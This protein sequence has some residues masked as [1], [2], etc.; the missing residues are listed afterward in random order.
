LNQIETNPP[1]QI[2]DEIKS[3]VAVARKVRAGDT[4]EIQSPAFQQT[5]GKIDAYYFDN[6]SGQ[7]VPAK[8]ID[9]AYDGL[10]PTYSAGQTRFKMENTGKEVHEMVIA[11]LKP[12]VNKT[13][14]QILKLPESQ[15]DK[16]VVNVTQAD[17]VPAGQS[18]YGSAN[19][20]AGQYNAICFIPQGSTKFPPPNGKGKPHFLL[21][22]QKE[23][24]VK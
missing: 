14:A 16:Y 1:E 7:K 4:K 22:M 20:T 11:R 21:G 3:A 12:G 24:T 8:A 2:A 15:A 10:K 9:F 6:C 23:F 5:T 13:F 18:S 17:P 19:L